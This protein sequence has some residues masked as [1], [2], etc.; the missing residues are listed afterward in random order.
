MTFQPNRF[1]TVLNLNITSFVQLDG[2]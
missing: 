1:N 2:P